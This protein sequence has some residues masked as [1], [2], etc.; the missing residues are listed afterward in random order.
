MRS[1]KSKGVR[2]GTLW[3]SSITDKGAEWI[4]DQVDKWQIERFPKSF[5][6]AEGAPESF[7]AKMPKEFWDTN[8][9]IFDGPPP[10]PLWTAIKT[11]WK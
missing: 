7:I 5:D 4:C 2:E 8:Y 6:A 3:G 11:L 1:D 9:F 10:N